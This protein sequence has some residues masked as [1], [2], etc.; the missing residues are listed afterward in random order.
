MNEPTA[1]AAACVP[2]R[3]AKHIDL[4]NAI[5]NVQSITAHLQDLKDKITGPTPAPAPPL[6]PENNSATPSL[7]E[8]LNG[9]STALRDKI[10]QAH[11]L[12]DEIDSLLL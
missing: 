2:Q 10:D 8:L 12:I 11:Q 9:S 7:V 4:H 1:I 5:C 6:A 3:P